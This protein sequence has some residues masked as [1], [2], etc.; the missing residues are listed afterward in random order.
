VNQAKDVSCVALVDKPVGPTSFEIVKKARQGISE[1]VGHAGT[2]DPFASGLLL[3]LV[4]R[5][6]RISNLLMERSKTY[7]VVVQFGSISSTADPTGE[8]RPTGVRTTEKEILE[9]IPIFHGRISQKVLLTSAVKVDGEALY[10][11]AHRGEIVDTP[12]REVIVHEFA[13]LDFDATTQQAKMLATTGSG[14]YVRAL[15]ED[16]GAALGVGA[17]AKELRRIRSGDLSVED[18]FPPDELS[19]ERY[20]AKG[21]GVLS[22]D[23]ALSFLPALLLKEREAHLAENGSPFMWEDAALWEVNKEVF[24][25]D[26]LLA[27]NNLG[28][29]NCQG[30]KERFRVH[31]SRGLIAIYEKFADKIRPLVVFP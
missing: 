26:V 3:I 5:A 4:G 23:E 20:F 6:T 19:K 22:I 11:K 29:M 16:L 1:K 12:K 8:L 24:A 18:A 28:T 31:G 21:N 30:G 2:L 17:Y 15:S 7:E 10:R 14:T 9:I 13:L 25:Q 27:T